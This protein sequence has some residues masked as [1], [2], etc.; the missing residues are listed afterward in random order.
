MFDR[1]KDA[2]ARCRCAENDSKVLKG[3]TKMAIRST[4]NVCL[5]A[6]CLCVLSYCPVEA[7]VINVPADQPTIQQAII[8]AGNGDEVVVAVGEYFENINLSGK[9]ITVRSTNPANPAVVVTTII[10]GGGAAA[11]VTCDGDEGRDT[12]ISGFVI[13]NGSAVTGA[14]MYNNDSSPTVSNCT[15]AGNVASI[16]GGGMY[17]N[18]SDPVVTNCAF[19]N[20]SASVYGAGMYNQSSDPEVTDCTFSD[21]SA[22]VNGGGMYNWS[23]TP[24][25]ANCTF[26]GNSAGFFGGGMYTHSDKPA[27]ADTVF[28]RNTPTNIH[29]AYT[30]N[31]GN[32][33]SDRFCPP[34][35]APPGICN[36]DLTGDGWLSPADLSLLVTELLPYETAYYWKPCE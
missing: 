12:V 13:T 27:I 9:P 35:E 32:A 4:Q 10:N 2:S 1:V 14:G 23:G 17:N 25:M 15:F 34:P 19:S 20:N 8:A 16:E 29:G 7:A 3:G 24:T 30:D 18:N 36:G 11:V 22:D 21:N 5:I 28:C 33:V 31:N 26:T 6:L